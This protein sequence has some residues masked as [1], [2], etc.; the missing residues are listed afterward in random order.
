[1]ETNEDV[2]ETYD[3]VVVGGGPAGL[4]GAIAMARS[5]RRVLVVDAG[6][7][8]NAPA[9]GA[10][11]LLGREGVK[12]TELLATGR[13][14]LA[15]YG[16]HL[17]HDEAV[18]ARRSDD[19]FVVT[20][21][22]GR[23]VA[24]RG[25]LVT[26][27]LT[28]ELPDVP[29]LADRWGHE[30]LHC[31]FCHGWEVRDQRIGVLSTGP[32]TTH[33]ALLFGQLSDRVTVLAHTA[34]PSSEDRASLDAMGVDVADGE[35]VAVVG[36]D[37]G[38]LTG[39]RLADGTVVDLDAVVVASRL[40]AASPVLADLGLEAVDHPSGAGVHYPSEMA[41]STSMPLLRLAGNVTDLMA[42]VGASAAAGVMAGAALHGDL[43]QADLA[44]RLAA[45][46]ATP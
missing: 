6:R 2:V 14:E 40:V 17:T 22:S 36:E 23:E 25:L 42:Q 7:P 10:H 30:V 4:S 28:D 32:M 9:E 26:S 29:G 13:D 15:S 11:N 35:V 5:R 46:A 1:M 43:I 44:A 33:Q 3:A 41:G 12:P 24:S 38:P 39:V 21:A 8:R 18:G 27:G 16:G 34:P 20:L 37:G 45:R 19:G 31:P